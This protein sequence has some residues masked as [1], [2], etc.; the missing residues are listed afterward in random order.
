MCNILVVLISMVAYAFDQEEGT[1]IT[2]KNTLFHIF[3]HF[4]D[5]VVIFAQSTYNA[6]TV[7]IAVFC[8]QI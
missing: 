6:F 8:V 7:I 5:S 3:V 1:N 2:S 4:R